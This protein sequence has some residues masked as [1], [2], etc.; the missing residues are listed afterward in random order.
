MT[1]ESHQLLDALDAIEDV[2]ARCLA[3][4]LVDETWDEADLLACLAAVAPGADTK[5][6]LDELVSGHLVLAVP[7]S[8]PIRYRTRMAEAVRLFARLRQLFP[9][10]PWQSSPRLVADFRFRHE[11]RQFPRRDVSPSAALDDLASH[12]AIG[13]QEHVALAAVLG[14]RQLSQFQLAAARS[15]FD[16]LDARSNRGVVVG[17]GT[18]SGKTLA[19]YLPALVHLATRPSLPESTGV[20]AIYPRNE[21]LKDQLATALDELRLLREAGGRSLRIGAYFGPTPSGPQYPP[22]ERTGWRRRSDGWLCPYLTCPERATDGSRCDGA[23]IWL[24]T[25]RRAGLEQLECSRCHGLV[26]PDEFALTRN[27]MQAHPPDLVFTTTEMLNRAI[28]DGWS[29]HIF[30]AG[31]RAQ[32]APALVLLDEVHT[33]E[34]VAG[35]QAAY[36]LRRWRKAVGR[37]MT[38]VGLSATLANAGAFFSSLCGLSEEAVTEVVPHPDDLYERG[39]EYQLVLRG[40]PASQ[41]ALL[42]T[43]IQALMLLRRVL[44]PTHEAAIAGAFGSRV[45]AFCD[46]LDL[47]NRLYRQF[48]DAEGL[49]PFGRPDP[50]RHLLAGLRLP[51]NAE[52][53]GPISDWPARDADGQHWWMVEDL[54]FGNRHL[55]VARTSSQDSGVD[56]LADVVVA[57]ASLEVGFDDPRVGAALQHKAPRDVAQFLQRRGRA[58]RTQTQRPW[59]VVVLSDYGRDRSAYQ[60]YETLLDPS[61][62]AKTL[63]LGNQSVRKMQ[64][65]MCL[66]DWTAIQLRAAGPTKFTARKVFS[67]PS[68]PS[69]L[70]ART[71]SLLRA[72]IDGGPERESLVRH[73]TTAL[74]LTPDEAVAVCWE[75]PRSLLLDVVPTAFRRVRSQWGRYIDGQIEA[76]AEPWERDA[77]L[78]EFIPRTL[79]SDLCLPEVDIEPPEGYDPAADTAM[80]VMQALN[81]L[82][83]GRVTL[84]WAVRKVK[85]LWIEPAIG[86]ELELEE[87]VAP[88]AEVLG[89]VMGLGGAP[90]PLVRPTSMRPSTPDAVTLPSSN[91]FLHWQFV[92]API[93]DGFKLIRPRRGPLVGLIQEVEVYLHAG[94]G[95]LRT[96]RYALQATS[97]VARRTGRERVVQSF[98]WRQRPA[99]LGYEAVV[100][101]LKVSLVLPHLEDLDLDTDQRRLR[102]L[103][104]DRFVHELRA[105]VEGLGHNPFLARW[106]TDVVSGAAALAIQ[107][108]SAVESLVGLSPTLW[109][110]LAEEAIQGVLLALDPTEE[111]EAPLRESVLTALAQVEVIAAI[112]AAIPALSE[113]PNSSWAPWLRG[114]ILQTVAAALQMA[115]QNLCPDFDVENDCIVDVLDK[116]DNAWVMLS[117]ASIGG[118]GPIEAL[119]SRISDDPRRFDQL[120]LASLEPSDLEEADASL[121]RALDLLRD[122]PTIA[123]VA[124]A[125][126]ASSHRRLDAWRGVTAALVV[127]GVSPTHATLSTLLSR[128][129]RPGSSVA[130]DDLLRKCLVRWSAIEASAG[131]AL[132][133]RSAAAVL[134]RDP[135]VRA[136]ISAAVPGGR[137]DDVVW[138]QVVLLGLLWVRAEERRGTSMRATNWFVRNPP[139]TERT[140]VLDLVGTQGDVVD[141]ASPEWRSVLADRLTAVGRCRLTAASSERTALRTALVDLETR[142]LELGWL[143]VH[144]RVEAITRSDGALTVEVS[145]EEAPQ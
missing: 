116:N 31:P 110:Q 42:S 49:D 102:Q 139:L 9:H 56:A 27:G 123:S 115:A 73:V 59:T 113:Q 32:R 19:F 26:R 133:Q 1:F 128:V 79:F 66:V 67:D 125:F 8:W 137:L 15:V 93:A 85:G 106:I 78:P 2:D 77:P 74:Q 86:G 20:V 126:R 119:A 104:R 3:W 80:P 144:P 12:P 136:H 94:S 97:D 95:A 132:D 108:G 129:F 25:A 22:D 84:R 98:T 63:P 30:G 58:G 11:P 72:V 17:A 96:W 18:G 38:F 75:Q 60:D 134:A 29:M 107:R 70:Q 53:Y 48:L 40:D 35:A 37:P 24:E 83:P 36:L 51:A 138:A 47:V 52:R 5:L 91:G 54:A 89:E 92:A 10:K 28:S 142:P 44:E 111:E 81:E 33:Y 127:R 71:A 76:Q 82:A 46:N 109:E 55:A 68:A 57:T 117:D 140:L 135:E 99:A 50:K 112:D 23:L 101:A 7:R 14:A 90:V 4:G 16:S 45:F 64:A 141:V 62:P 131:F 143:L 34:G 100:D 39:R 120:V 69:S 43:S 118:G 105:G 130:S 88:T 87:Q 21:L 124:A 65:A 41:A 103:R 61:L 13:P 122:E 121:P 145:L 114:R 6:L